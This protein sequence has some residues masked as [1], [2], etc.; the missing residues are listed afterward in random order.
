[1]AFFRYLD[2]DTVL[3]LD[4][5]GEVKVTTNELEWMI[6]N[7]VS[8][9][10][11]S[12]CSSLFSFAGAFWNFVIHSYGVSGKSEGYVT[13][14]LGRNN[15][16]PPIPLKVSFSFKTLDGKKDGERNDVEHYFINGGEGYVTFRMILRDDLLNRASELLPSNNLTVLC[17]VKNLE[18]TENTSKCYI[19]NK[20]KY[21][22]FEGLSKSRDL[23]L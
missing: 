6:P 1:M 9:S 17:S 19:F 12:H 7:F 14:S 8:L 15:P 2:L 10:K 22:K 18:A 5:V 16:V 13:I 11:K 23:S 21:L 20:Q 3:P 4:N